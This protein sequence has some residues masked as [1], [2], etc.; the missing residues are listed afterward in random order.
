MYIEYR[1]IFN[2]SNDCITSSTSCAIASDDTTMTSFL[3]INSTSDDVVEAWSDD[4]LHVTLATV[5]VT[6]II[7]IIILGHFLPAQ[8]DPQA[9]HFDDLRCLDIVRYHLFSASGRLV[10]T[11]ARCRWPAVVCAQ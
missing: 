3:W 8:A 9:G 2:I 1:M 6:V 7:V 5:A 10:E 4:W 11:T